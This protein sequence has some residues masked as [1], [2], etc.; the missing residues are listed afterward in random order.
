[1]GR[2]EPG[3]RAGRGADCRSAGRAGRRA[4]HAGR[5]ADA[6]R[7]GPTQPAGRRVERAAARRAGDADAPAERA[8]ARRPRG[9]GRTQGFVAPVPELGRQGRAPV[10]RCADA[11]ALHPRALVDA[12]HPRFHLGPQ[13]RPAG[14]L[15]QRLLRPPRAQPA[16]AVDEG[17]RARQRLA[18]PCGARRFTGG[19]EFAAALREHGRIGADD[20]HRPAL[21]REVWLQL[22]ALR[23]QARRDAQRRRSLHAR[24]RD[25]QGLP[26]HLGAGPAFVPDLSARPPAAGARAVDREWLGVRADFG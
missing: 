1:M 7:N 6:T 8:A 20:L 25:G 22:P 24:T 10:V 21:R 14:R 3:A 23:A 13:D 15:D 19:D 18:E 12:G 17:L 16:R 9:L 5:S 4:D 2:A 26:R 11:A